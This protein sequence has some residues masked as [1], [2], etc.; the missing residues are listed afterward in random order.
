MYNFP[1]QKWQNWNEAPEAQLSG[2]FKHVSVSMEVFFACP[3]NATENTSI[4]MQN[5]WNYVKI[6]DNYI[7]RL[8]HK[9]VAG[10]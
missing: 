5:H 1:F 3:K 2:N 4:H 7:E 8:K 9:L 6:Y 10:L